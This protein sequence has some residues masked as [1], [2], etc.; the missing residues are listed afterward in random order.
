[1]N[2]NHWLVVVVGC[3]W[4][5]D[6]DS[7]NGKPISGQTKVYG[8][9]W[10]VHNNGGLRRVNMQCERHVIIMDFIISCTARMPHVGAEHHKAVALAL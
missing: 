5:W 8:L 6:F 7:T 2:S 4:A 9:M 10:V 3:K 1:M